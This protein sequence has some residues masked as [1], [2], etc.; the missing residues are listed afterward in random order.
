MADDQTPDDYGP[1]FANLPED[2]A[3]QRA[4]PSGRI[5][6]FG[7][8][9][10]LVGGVA[11][12]MMAEGARRLASGDSVSARELILT[13]GN[14]QR[15]TDRLSHLRGAAMKMGQ[16]ISLD[17]GDFLPDELSKILATL[18]DQANFM[19]TRQLD[20]VLKSE[21]GPDW[22]KQFR[23]VQ[24]PARFGGGP[25]SGRCTKGLGTRDGEETGDQ[26]AISRRRQKAS[27][28]MSTMSS[29]C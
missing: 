21:W 8:F 13:P 29:R 24:P 26:G 25:A 3:R 10:R 7:T 22:R 9:G 19:P 14:V 23:L 20:Q 5:A 28:A 6:R 2:R 1:D 16:M 4:V 27:T 18:R 11:G 17:A 12:G 15:L